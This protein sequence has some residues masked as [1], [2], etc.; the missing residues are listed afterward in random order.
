MPTA[1]NIDAL[2]PR[3][4]PTKSL[5]VRSCH[6][7]TARACTARA[8]HPKA[9]VAHP[10]DIQSAP[11]CVRNPRAY[12]PNKPVRHRDEE[13]APEKE[14]A[15]LT[16]APWIP[17]AQFEAGTRIELYVASTTVVVFATEAALARK[18]ANALAHLA[19][20]YYPRSAK[21]VLTSY[22]RT[23]GDGSSCRLRRGAA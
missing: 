12:E 3:K 19:A 22:L 1:P 9:G 23:P 20:R 14:R 21:G 11:E 8:T 17:A 5:A 10:L 13:L 7:D 18:A 6:G 2:R 16:P 15:V 4:V